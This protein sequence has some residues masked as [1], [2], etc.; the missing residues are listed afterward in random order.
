VHI[1][2]KIIII[3][4][5]ILRLKNNKLTEQKAI[6]LSSLQ[7]LFKAL[8]KPTYLDDEHYY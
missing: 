1:L 7:C 8:D 3:N 4:K 5:S 2:V 6:K